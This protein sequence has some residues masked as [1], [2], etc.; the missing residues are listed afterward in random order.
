M[1]TSIAKRRL[2]WF[3]D[4]PQLQNGRERK[5]DA[6]TRRKLGRPNI[7]GT[8][9][10]IEQSTQVSVVATYNRVRRVQVQV[11]VPQPVNVPGWRI[12]R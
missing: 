4:E 7:P 1:V 12:T 5:L 6:K 3:L 8:I 9:L 2:L 11:C 10:C